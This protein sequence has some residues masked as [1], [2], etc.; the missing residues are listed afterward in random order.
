[1]ILVDSAEN[2]EQPVL[3]WLLLSHKCGSPLDHRVK[4]LIVGTTSFHGIGHHVGEVLL[5]GLVRTDSES[6]NFVGPEAPELL[7]DDAGEELDG[8]E[9]VVDGRQNVLVPFQRLVQ[10]SLVG[11][12]SPGLGGA[13]VAVLDTLSWLHVWRL[14]A[15]FNLI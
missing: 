3:G 2:L 6:V 1:M 14:S 8:A 12:Y 5:V 10:G 4:G 15:T 11:H 7:V 13:N 9:G